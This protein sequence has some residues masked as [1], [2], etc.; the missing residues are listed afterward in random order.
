VAIS[1]SLELFIAHPPPYPS[2]PPDN[3]Y[4]EPI[5]QRRKADICGETMQIEPE[6]GP[7]SNF[8]IYLFKGIV[9]GFGY[10]FEGL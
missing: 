8:Y 3:R 9:S 10:F 6:N 2:P 4:S 1:P 7:S 5:L